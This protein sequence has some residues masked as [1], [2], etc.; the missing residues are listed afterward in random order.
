MRLQNP[1]PLSLIVAAC[2]FGVAGCGRQAAPKP[3][4]QTSVE[5]AEL[6]LPS[7]F[8]SIRATGTVGR[9]REAA[10]SFRIPGIMSG[11]S[12]DVGDRVSQGQQIAILDARDATARLNQSSAELAQAE[13]DAR[14]LDGLVEAGAISRQQY[15]A[16]RTRAVSARAAYQAAAF[17]S[18]SA[19]RLSPVSGV[20]LS[21]TA[22]RGEVVQPS[23]PIITVADFSSPLILRLPVADRDVARIKMGSTA[24][25]QADALGPGQITGRVTR[26][27]QQ[28]GAQDGAIEVEVTLPA[29]SGLLSGM[30]ATASISTTPMPGTATYARLPAEA[31]LEASN[32]RAYVM[33]YDASRRIARRTAISFGGFDGDDALVGGL[34]EGARIITGGAGYVADGDRVAINTSAPQ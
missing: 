31:I 23:Q 10:L 28:A 1:L 24:T 22:Q 20:V 5:I 13:R 30:V 19:R 14:R 16:A 18:R 8:A 25:I 17:D 9:A 15:D 12:V 26:I 4:P 3:P 34:P 6:R 29:S 32:G 27:G 11:L 33:R 2:S 21:R 7:G